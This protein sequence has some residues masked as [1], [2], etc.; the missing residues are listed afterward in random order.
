ML[1]L[2]PPRDLKAVV[3]VCRWWME[4]GEAP[5]LW[6]WL[7]LRMRRRTIG[8][9]PVV[10][11]SRRLQAVRRLELRGL[12]AVSEEVLQ[13]LARHPGLEEMG[14]KWQLIHLFSKHT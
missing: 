10:L 5:A 12:N 11:D 7:C 2:L 8:Y 6:V 14:I 4:V 3:L 1:H 9:M 13:A